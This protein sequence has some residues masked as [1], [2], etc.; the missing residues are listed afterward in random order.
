MYL[1]ILLMRLVKCKLTFSHVRT[2]NVSKHEAKGLQGDGCGVWGVWVCVGLIEYLVCRCF[3]HGSSPVQ[4]KG[5][6]VR[7]F[8]FQVK[9]KGNMRNAG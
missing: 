5:L 7:I 8:I 2:G 3:K 6:L 9:P 4:F 1:C